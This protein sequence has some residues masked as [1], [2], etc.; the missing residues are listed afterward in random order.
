M[1]KKTEKG[2]RYSYIWYPWRVKNPIKFLYRWIK[3]RVF[4]GVRSLVFDSVLNQWRI[5]IKPQG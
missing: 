1:R 3:F 5:D 2:E 4:W